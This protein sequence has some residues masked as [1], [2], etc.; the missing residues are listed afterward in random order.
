[1]RTYS[2]LAALFAELAMLPL[3]TGCTKCQDEPATKSVLIP[4]ATCSGDCGEWA[5]KPCMETC[6]AA[7]ADTPDF[8]ITS[9]DGPQGVDAGTNEQRAD[10]LKVY[11]HGTDYVCKYEGPSF[12]GRLPHGYSAY[13][14]AVH[15][16]GAAAAYFER[17]AHLEHASVTAFE[18]IASRLDEANAPPDL[19]AR[20]LL[21]ANDERRHTEAMLD[22]ARAYGATPDPLPD[23]PWPEEISLQHLLLDNAVSGC[24]HETWSALQAE[25]LARHAKDAR[26]R[27]VFKDIARE[28]AMHAA[29]SWD[30]ARAL[31]PQLSDG[32]RQ[33]LNIA[34]ASAFDDLAFPCPREIMNLRTSDVFILTRA[35]REGLEERVSC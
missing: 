35:F 8:V 18:W 30:I 34:R 11:C 14:A 32:D 13:A 17:A 33:A 25:V 1:M 24:V 7:L 19:I 15:G 10:D 23:V 9:C 12:G 20:C 28:E 21:A 16:G 3:L 26:V 29:L 31:E 4:A 22:L 2:V 6:K 5:T 27:D